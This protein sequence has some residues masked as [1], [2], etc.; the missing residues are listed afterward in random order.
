MHHKKTGSCAVFEKTFGRGVS[1][2][3]SLKENP[4]QSHVVSTQKRAAISGSVLYHEGIK[5]HS[6]IHNKD[7]CTPS[8][9]GSKSPVRS[10]HR[11]F[12]HPNFGR[13]LS[14][15]DHSSRSRSQPPARIVCK[16]PT[17]E[18][19]QFLSARNTRL[20]YKKRNGNNALFSEL[21]EEVS[22]EGPCSVQCLRKPPKF[23][24]STKFLAFTST[25]CGTQRTTAVGNKKTVNKLSTDAASTDGMEVFRG[26]NRNSSYTN[27][28]TGCRT[29][30]NALLCESL[31]SVHLSESDEKEFRGSQVSSSDTYHSCLDH[32]GESRDLDDILVNEE[33]SRLKISTSKR[34]SWSKPDTHFTDSS[35]SI[36]PINLV[37]RDLCSLRI[38]AHEENAYPQPLHCFTERNESVDLD[39]CRRGEA[40]ATNLLKAS[41]GS[42]HNENESAPFSFSFLNDQAVW[43]GTTDVSSSGNQFCK[44]I[45]T[46]EGA[47]ASRVNT[48]TSI[49]YS[50]SLQCET[51]R[52]GQKALSVRSQENGRDLYSPHL[53]AS[54]GTVCTR[55]VDSLKRFLSVEFVGLSGACPPVAPEVKPQP[56]PSQI[57]PLSKDS[58]LVLNPAILNKFSHPSALN[59]TCDDNNNPSL[60]RDQTTEPTTRTATAMVKVHITPIRSY[61]PGKGHKRIRKK[62]EV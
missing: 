6:T 61:R 49:L 34:A 35:K 25:P 16:K 27:V 19:E 62:R 18:Q 31:S 40:T 33:L 41:Q 50:P 5:T 58:I 8:S 2:K 55:P 38:L 12:R 37:D 28:E 47:L 46:R 3:T 42:L 21:P 54:E 57:S 17:H 52:K 26:S 30:T 4:P 45:S 51:Y 24:R 14:V 23:P 15:L 22:S 13:D 60:M 43:K 36:E 10:S 44:Q 39:W 59:S 32:E 20:K 48:S 11:N 7:I 1:A 29:L 53:S 9:E 56:Y